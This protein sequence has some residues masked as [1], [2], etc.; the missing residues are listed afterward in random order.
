MADPLISDAEAPSIRAAFELFLVHTATIQPYTSGA[1]DAHGDATQTAGTP[2]T[3]VP[4]KYVSEA[5]VRVR[6]DEGGV[7]IVR[8]PTLTVAHDDP[9]DETDTVSN[10]TASD[11]TVL[12]AGPIQVGPPVHAAGFGPVLSKRFL[13]RGGE[14]TT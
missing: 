12:L 2:R 1:E 10:I 14:V 9:L 3:G 6:N 4:C 8:A 11:G 7:T 5:R 13:L